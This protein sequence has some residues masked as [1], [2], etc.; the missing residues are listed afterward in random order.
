MSY[1]IEDCSVYRECVDINGVPIYIF[2]EHNMALLACGTICSKI[3]TGVN[4]ITFD[5]H[6]DTL[7]M[8]TKLKVKMNQ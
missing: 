4:L 3:G 2:E 6:M 7:H 8:C 1:S 5:T